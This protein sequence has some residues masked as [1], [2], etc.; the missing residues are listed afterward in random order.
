M[1][2]CFGPV[3]QVSNYLM[4]GCDQSHNYIERAEHNPSGQKDYITSKMPEG[5]S[6]TLR[7]FFFPF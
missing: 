6:A 4:T 2:R 7:V 1:E 5:R 3:S